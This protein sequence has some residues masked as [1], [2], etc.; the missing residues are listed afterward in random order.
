MEVGIRIGTVMEELV[1]GPFFVYRRNARILLPASR[2]A[3]DLGEKSD[4]GEMKE[5]AAARTSS[6]WVRIGGWRHGPRVDKDASLQ[7]EA[8]ERMPVPLQ[9]T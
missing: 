8:L 9:E 1:Q 4:P 6:R 7:F 2:A 5:D 3:A